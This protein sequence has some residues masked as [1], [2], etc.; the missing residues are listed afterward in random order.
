[1]ERK[2][3]ASKSVAPL[4]AITLPLAGVLLLL[5]LWCAGAWGQE[6]YSLRE[7]QWKQETSLDPATP[8]GQLQLGRKALAQGQAKKAQKIA[9]RWIKAN[10]DHPLMV[11]ARL[12]KGDARAARKNYYKALFDYEYVIREFPASE[13]FNLAIEREF[14]I[15]ELFAA[16]VKRKLWGMPI[17][18]A[19]GEAE[20]IFILIQE[21]APGSPIGERASLTLADYYF[22]KGEMVSASD[23]YNLFLTNYP[24]SEHR[25][26]AML[27][28]IQANLARFHGPQFDPTGLIEAAQHVRRYAQEYPVAA[29][30]LGTTAIL[31]RIDESLAAKGMHTA[32]WYEKRKE[33]VS[34]SYLYRRILKEHPTSPAAAK[35]LARL[36]QINQWPAPTTQSSPTTQPSDESADAQTPLETPAPAAVP[37]AEESANPPATQPAEEPTSPT[38]EPAPPES[39]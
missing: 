28:L 10:P 2:R 37:S 1:M 31:Q 17:L 8:E 26:R 30:K 14:Q 11:E 7:G 38:Q 4:P 39:K 5:S 9:E 12:L 15:A 21:R 23:S 34:A 19:G 16:G 22:K 32:Q 6:K 36:E 3:S 33:N 20:E 18:P 24:R 27:R 29:E 35:S 25:E 13:Q